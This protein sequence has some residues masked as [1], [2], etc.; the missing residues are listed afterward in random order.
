V[1]KA[2]TDDRGRL[3]KARDRLRGLQRGDSM[4]REL[5][6]ELTLVCRTERSWNVPCT[7]FLEKVKA[8]KSR[9]VVDD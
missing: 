1:H 6:H 4:D 9:L 7:T 3:R 8:V 2:Q 5:E